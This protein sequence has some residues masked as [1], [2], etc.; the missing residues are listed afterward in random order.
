[1]LVKFGFSYVTLPSMVP[2]IVF[3]IYFVRAY[4]MLGKS[5]YFLFR[6]YKLYPLWYLT[7]IIVFT[8]I[9]ELPRKF[10][11]GIMSCW[12]HLPV[13]WEFLIL[14]IIHWC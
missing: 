6:R 13:S 5:P 12:K 14:I 3:L 1:M 2:Y 4:L 8:D 7:I 11:T 9:F 10:I